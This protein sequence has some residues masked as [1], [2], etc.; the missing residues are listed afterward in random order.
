MRRKDREITDPAKIRAIIS[1]CNCCRLGFVDGESVYIVPLS[2]G[3]CEHNGKRTFYFH[4]ADEGRK[5]ELIS[6]N[7]C[8]GFELDTN[9][10]LNES[11]KACGYSAGFQSVIGTGRVTSVKDT[12]EKRKALVS[13]M[14]QNTGKKDWEFS[15]EMFE[16]VS[17]FKLEVTELSCK[18]HL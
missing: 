11:T 5:I 3:Y 6:K 8:A 1:A 15:E 7:P 9:Y 12:D 10:K 14:H 2:F 4:G 18:E 13:L 17:V 16:A